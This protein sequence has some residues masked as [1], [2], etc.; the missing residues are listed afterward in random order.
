MFGYMTTAS[1][2]T[3]VQ[4]VSRCIV[5]RSCAIGTASTVWASAAVEHRPGPAARPRRRSSARRPRRRRRRARA[6]ARRR[7]RPARCR[8]RSSC[9]VPANRG[10]WRVDRPGQRR[11]PLAGRHRQAGDRDLVAD[12]HAR[13]AGEQQVGQRVDHEVV[14]VHEAVG[15]PADGRDL[16]VRQA[17]H[18]DRRQVGGV[19]VV[20]VAPRRRP[21]STSPS[22]GSASTPAIVSS[23]ACSTSSASTSRSAR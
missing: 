10:W 8:A 4:T 7:P 18:Q 16:L 11:L 2:S 1:T 23:R 17:G 20:Q 19:Q 13:V 15:Q 12:P 21:C 9:S 3:I 14:P 22:R 6:A 5:A